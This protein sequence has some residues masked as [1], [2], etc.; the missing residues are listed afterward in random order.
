MIFKVCLGFAYFVETEIFLLKVLLI[1]IK[2]N[3]NNIVEPMN[4][5]KKCS[6]IHE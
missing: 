3:W 2:V 4:S 5:T 1:K 6:G